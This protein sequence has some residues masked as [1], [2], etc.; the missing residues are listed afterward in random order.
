MESSQVGMKEKGWNNGLLRS[1]LSNGDLV[2]C[3]QRNQPLFLQQSCLCEGANAESMPTKASSAFDSLARQ[4][5]ENPNT[6]F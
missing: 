6:S 3:S 5:V 2:V 1:Y 4:G